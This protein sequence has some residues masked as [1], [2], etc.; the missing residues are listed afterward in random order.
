MFDFNQFDAPVARYSDGDLIIEGDWV[1]GF[2]S[3]HGVWHHGFIRRVVPTYGSG[4]DLEIIHNSKDGGVIV[5]ALSEFADGNAT[6]VRHPDSAHHQRM[7]LTRAD[8]NYR[9]PYLLL[10]QNC[11]HFCS[12]CYTGNAVSNT[13][14][15]GVGV[16]ALGLGVA[17]FAGAFD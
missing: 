15:A 10:S 8:A 4:Y 1:K 11:E 9:K 2:S 5:S 3:A 7:I 14:A 16:V 13:V 12:F 6:L 17:F